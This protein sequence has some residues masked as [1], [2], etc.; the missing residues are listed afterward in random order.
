MIDA[1][2]LKYCSEV[3]NCL[4]FAVNGPA[5]ADPEY[6][7][8]VDANNIIVEIDNEISECLSS[9]DPGIL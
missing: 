5:E 3:V 9:G 8:I 4:V 6:Q 2:G 7:V 1:H